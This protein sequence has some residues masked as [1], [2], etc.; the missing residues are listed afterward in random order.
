MF[1][2]DDVD[3]KLLE[4]L[5]DHGRLPT[6]ELSRRSGI[7][8]ATVNRR[9]RKLIDSGIIKRFTYELDNEKLGR[10]MVVY[11]LIRAKPGANQYD[12]LEQ[13]A[14]CQ[15]VE[16]VAAITGSFDLLLKVRVKDNEELS[17]FLFKNVRGF[18]SVAQTETMVKLSLKPYMETKKTK[19]Q[20]SLS[21]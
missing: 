15:E 2:L 7:P 16:D 10:N 11:V 19:L 13:A 4:V 6:R 8:F 21:K 14:K 9:M 3:K 1:Q 20:Q 17:E 5:K 18:D 12:I